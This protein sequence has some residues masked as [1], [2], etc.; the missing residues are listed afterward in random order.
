MNLSFNWG[1]TRLNQFG[2]RPLNTLDMT[3]LS[4]KG[5]IAHE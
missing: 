5:G 1:Q 3:I 4:M 2:L